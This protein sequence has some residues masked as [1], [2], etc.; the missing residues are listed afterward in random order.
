MSSVVQ[1]LHRRGLLHKSPPPKF[2]PM[3][4]AYE[5]IMGSEAYGVSSGSSD[6][7]VY[8][9]CFPEK[10]MIFPHLAGFIPDFGT[11]PPKF[12]VWQ[13][14][15][16]M[17][18]DRG[19]EYDLAIY[20]I[21]KYFQLCM[22][23][24]PN[25][26][27]SLFTPRRCV[28]HTTSVGER[29]RENRKLFLS[30]RAWH[31]F[32]GYAHSQM[33]KIDIKRSAS[34]AAPMIRDLQEFEWGADIPNTT[35]FAEVEAEFKAPTGKFPKIDGQKLEWYYQHYLA[36]VEKNK[37]LEGVKRFGFDVKFAYHVVRLMNEAKQILVEH[38]LDLERNS[39]QL[40]SI[41][42]GEWSYQRILEYFQAEERALEETCSRSTLR[43]GPDEAALT[44][45]LLSCIE[46]HYGTVSKAVV[47]GVD[48][49]R[50][51]REMQDV[52]DKFSPKG[53]THGA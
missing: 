52:I 10:E 15:H 8:G 34:D 36:L 33:H 49:D 37:R 28:L 24:N 25:M 23:C 14:H 20:G 18:P 40:K 17:D 4:M 1:D 21:V 3:N 44:E 47:R 45:L 42:R 38:D 11:H 19:K 5:T 30:Q 27:D 39:E 31:K 6:V 26:I 46:S 16:A 35:T 41:R 29:V 2:L 32:K 51:I 53:D 7:D 50:L 9:F 43:W 12:E 48:V 22:D 13:H